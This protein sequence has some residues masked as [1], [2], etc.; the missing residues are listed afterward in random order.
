M[1]A[2]WWLSSLPFSGLESVLF[3]SL[4]RIPFLSPVNIVRLFPFAFCLLNLFSYPTRGL[5]INVELHA[6]GSRL[7][8]CFNRN[9]HKQNFINLF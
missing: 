3:H 1:K 5:Y 7:K 6:A 8:P 9:L 2:P 4:G